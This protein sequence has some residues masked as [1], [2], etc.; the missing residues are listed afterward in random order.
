MGIAT[1]R[2]TL[3][4]RLASAYVGKWRLQKG[5]ETKARPRR[6]RVAA[7]PLQ[8]ALVPRWLASGVR[9]DSPDGAR[10]A[11]R[12]GGRPGACLWGV[13]PEMKKPTVAQKTNHCRQY[14]ANYPQPDE[15]NLSA[16]GSP[17]AA[18]K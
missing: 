12:L 17:T 18:P 7:K 6:A 4:T 2:D 8:R 11:A 1:R 3:A 13:A 16:A 9:R 10:V 15:S 14:A 5:R